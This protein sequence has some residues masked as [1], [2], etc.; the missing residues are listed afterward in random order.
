VFDASFADDVNSDE[1]EKRSALDGALQEKLPPDMDADDDQPGAGSSRPEA[2]TPVG[3]ARPS[4]TA[5]TLTPTGS[6]STYAKASGLPKGGKKS[7]TPA[8]PTYASPDGRPLTRDS[9]RADIDA[10]EMLRNQKKTLVA[11]VS[12][13]ATS[14]FFATTWWS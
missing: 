7:L 9:T 12:E 11:I 13:A 5:G 2:I 10:L 3:S 1:E 4:V 6:S 14:G 8:R